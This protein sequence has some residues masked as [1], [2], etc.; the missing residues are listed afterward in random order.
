MST[1]L[2][3]LASVC[4]GD[5]TDQVVFLGGASIGLWISDAAAPPVRATNDVDVV[6]GATYQEL[7]T[8]AADL[9]K[10]AFREDRTVICRY[11]HP[12]G[13][14]LDVMPIDPMVL[15]FG[16]QWYR[17]AVVQAAAVV[18]PS[19]RMIRALRPPWLVATKLEAYLDRGADDPVAS[20]DFEDVVRLV[21]GRAQLA[22][23]IAVAPPP[24]RD[25]IAEEFGRLARRGDFEESIEGALPPDSGSRAR[26]EIVITRWRAIAETLA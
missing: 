13:L 7:D 2:L 15:G 17:E 20:A 16:N 10:R 8:F 1:A 11:H 21:D 3:E 9:R 18:L 22:T 12:D 6:I 24:I 14:V 25:F 26:A 5:L 19:G 4:L 23:E